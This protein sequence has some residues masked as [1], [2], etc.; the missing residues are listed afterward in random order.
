MVRLLLLPSAGALVGG[1]RQ[2]QPAA[3]H[4]QHLAGQS[5]SEH[6]VDQIMSSPFGCLR[7]GTQAFPRTCRSLA[8]LPLGRVFQLDTVASGG[9]QPLRAPGLLLHVALETHV[10]NQRLVPLGTLGL[11]VQR[12][13]GLPH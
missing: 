6:L 10:V 8:F 1:V 5:V 4:P 7:L 11:P 13:D 12:G 2:S 9:S 3:C